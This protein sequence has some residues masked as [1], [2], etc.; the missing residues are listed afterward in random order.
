MTWRARAYLIATAV[1]HT[2]AG[3]SCLLLPETFDGDAFQVVR[4]IAPMWAWGILFL[5]GGIHLAYAAARSSEIAAR[6]GMPLSALM[7]SLWAAGF[8]L[9]F[10]E[11]GAV[12]PI[13]AILTASLTFKDLIVCGQPMRSPFEPLVK[14]Y[15]STH[16]GA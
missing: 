11:G 6:V 13:G 2:L 9:A 4:T 15:A 3:L 5:A 7:I 1:Q 14:E 12:S 16:R 8:V 10:N